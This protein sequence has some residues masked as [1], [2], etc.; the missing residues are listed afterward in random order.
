MHGTTWHGVT[1][2]SACLAMLCLLSVVDA[3]PSSR[4]RD[5][6]HRRLY[7]QQR[8]QQ[9]QPPQ[10]YR[11]DATPD[12]LYSWKFRSHSP[13]AN[14]MLRKRQPEVVPT[15]ANLPDDMD[16]VVDDED[17]GVAFDKS[18]R[19]E[20]Y[21]HMRFGKRTAALAGGDDGDDYGHMRFGKRGE[22][23]Q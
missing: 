5:R 15:N 12:S 9:L 11:M 20:E 17:A 7:Q 10:P 8:Q 22:L 2:L 23:L 21:G 19:F 18:K 16:F 6:E 13:I 1:T 14:P 3:A 4:M